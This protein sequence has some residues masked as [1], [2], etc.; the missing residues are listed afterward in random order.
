MEIAGKSNLVDGK[1][2]VDGNREID[3]K[4]VIDGKTINKMQTGAK[5]KEAF[6]EGDDAMPPPP[7]PY[8]VVCQCPHA[9]HTTGGRRHCNR[10]ARWGPPV[11]AYWTCWLCVEHICECN[12]INCGYVR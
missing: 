1:K 5:K 11:V 3:G 12:C 9:I 6:D 2:E 8:G 4:G 10:R 7:T